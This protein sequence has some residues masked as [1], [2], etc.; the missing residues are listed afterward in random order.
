MRTVVAKQ[1][2]PFQAFFVLLLA[3]VTFY[4]TQVLNFFQILGI[5]GI[6][7]LL[8][9]SVLKIRAF[10]IVLIFLKP[11]IDLTWNSHFFKVGGDSISSLHIVGLYVFLVAAY[12]YLFER[13][14]RKIF[15]ERIIWIFLGLHI[16]ISFIAIEFYDRK[17]IDSV[18]TLLR[19]FDS[20]LIYFVFH[21]FLDDDKGKLR[22]ISLVWISTLLISL[23]SVIMFSVGVYNIDITGVVVRFAG[24]YN[25]PGIPS[26]TAIMSLIFG[27][28]YLEILRRKNKLTLMILVTY[29]LTIFVT[30]FILKVTITKS[31]L[32]MLSV[33]LILWI[34]I[35][36]KKFF[37]IFPILLLAGYF[38][39]TASASLQYRLENEIT[40]FKEGEFTLEA[41]RSIGT[42]R[43]GYWERIIKYYDI[44][45]NPFQK[46]FGKARNYGA[47][48]QY[49][50][51]L[52][53]VGIVGLSVFLIIL[54]RFY[55]RLI[56]LFKRY[57]K[58]ELFGAIVLL[59]IFS[60]YGMTGHP[61]EYTTLLWYLMILLS[62]INVDQERPPSQNL[63][64][65]VK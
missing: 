48:N 24:L 10:L 49:I 4:L 61:F 39:Y 52:M 15:N 46:F 62:L 41:A 38:A 34:G 7:A 6:V 25:D 33:F 57:K 36:K 18:D 42:G 12:L 22:I 56:H 23:L 37:V 26:Y 59:T 27:T 19:L 45:Y 2:V 40:F 17:I 13:E 53:Q 8:I 58:P 28:L 32:L 47:H 9:I 16:S 60:V 30:L 51:Y 29:I 55:K 43:I 3:I 14:E 35:F 21:R 31:A 63:D 11:F 20:Y 65:T 64:Q 1:D 44:Y 50:A 54:F 5:L